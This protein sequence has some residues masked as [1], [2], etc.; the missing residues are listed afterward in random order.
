VHFNQIRLR[1][2]ITPTRDSM[3]FKII[4]QASRFTSNQTALTMFRPAQATLTTYLSEIKVPERG[5]KRGLRKL[6]KRINVRESA[7]LLML[8]LTMLMEHARCFIC[9]RM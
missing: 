2:L 1:S 4:N 6:K 5:S 9:F 8:T 3:T 7:R